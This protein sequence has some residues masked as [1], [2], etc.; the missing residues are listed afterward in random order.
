MT[1][2]LEKSGKGHSF[3]LR[4]ILFDPLLPN[5]IL[6]YSHHVNVTNSE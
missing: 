4:S 5:L 3:F 6:K 1:D 2:L